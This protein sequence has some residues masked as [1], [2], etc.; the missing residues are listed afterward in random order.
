MFGG[1][2]WWATQRTYGFGNWRYDEASKTITVKPI[3]Q[4]ALEDIGGDWQERWV[5]LEPDGH[6]LQTGGSISSGQPSEMSFQ[7]TGPYGRTLAQV[8]QPLPADGFHGADADGAAGVV[9]FGV[10]H[11]LKDVGMWL[12]PEPLLG[13]PDHKFTACL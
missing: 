12:Q 10:R 8:G 5:F 7:V 11:T 2:H 4:M 13:S 1:A 3:P 6:T 9:P